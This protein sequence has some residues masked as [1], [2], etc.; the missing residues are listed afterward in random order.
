M[1]ESDYYTIYG[2]PIYYGGIK[3]VPRE[4]IEEIEPIINEITFNETITTSN[5]ERYKSIISDILKLENELLDLNKDDFDKNQSDK[6]NEI[7]MKLATI[8]SKQISE[9]SMDSDEQA[10]IFINKL[11]VPFSD[12]KRSDGSDTDVKYYTTIQHIEDSESVTN[13]AI[14][15]EEQQLA[16]ITKDIEPSQNTISE[17]QSSDEKLNELR[18]LF[19]S[20][21]KNSDGTISRTKLILKA[22]KDKT[23][24]DLL[25]LPQQIRQEDGTRDQFEILFQEI[26]ADD[27]KGLDWEEFQAHFNNKP[28]QDSPKELPQQQLSIESDTAIRGGY[29]NNFDLLT[30]QNNNI[31][32]TDI[33]NSLSSFDINDYSDIISET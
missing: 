33:E 31:T 12:V 11:A 17:E 4:P 10:A 1:F 28:N 2:E 15:S 30:N 13:V 9:N 20:I 14:P 8:L 6:L 21:D 32:E 22:R 5:K 24:A 3:I 25:Q 23:I 16:V 18:N 7:R 29:N 27:S 26:D 19:D